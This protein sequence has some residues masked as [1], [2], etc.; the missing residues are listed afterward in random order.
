MRE[1]YLNNNNIDS[2]VKEVFLDITG[3]TKDI[4][5]VGDLSDYIA[6]GYN[7]TKN[8]K[9]LDFIIK[10]INVFNFLKNNLKSFIRKEN[11]LNDSL[12]IYTIFEFNIRGIQV[13]FYLYNLEIFNSI[14]IEKIKLFGH[15]VNN[16]VVKDRYI[17]HKNN[18]TSINLN[19]RNYHL[20]L[21]EVYDK[22]FYRYDDVININNR[23]AIH[24]IYEFI[25]NSSLIITEDLSDY[26]NLRD[27]NIFDS[28]SSDITFI[29]FKYDNLRL[30]GEYFKLI[31]KDNVYNKNNFDI[32]TTKIFDV[33]V[34]F[35]VVDNINFFNSINYNIKPL[36]LR[37]VKVLSIN[38]C[39]NYHKNEL[40]NNITNE[41]FNVKNKHS[42][43]F[44]LYKYLLDNN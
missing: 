20:S 27:F 15:N 37:N 23:I 2:N 12:G 32:Y 42:R 1:V 11:N 25:D 34:N 4:I 7:F 40:N 43:L 30:L 3:I 10:D 22:V 35:L 36:M 14:S 16:M 28:F 26:I 6:L 21:L 17:Y 5:L 13:F 31:K 9:H 33:N 29:V 24:H 41:S 18:C 8:V 39:I 38:E 44:S 19:R